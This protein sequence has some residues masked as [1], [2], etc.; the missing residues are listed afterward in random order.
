VRGPLLALAVG[1]LVAVVVFVATRG[2]VVFLPLLLV[3]LVFV[4]P[5]GR[6]GR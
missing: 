2:H 4:W 5:R 3:P 6:K 1:L